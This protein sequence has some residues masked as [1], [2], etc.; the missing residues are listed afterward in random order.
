MPDRRNLLQHASLPGPARRCSRCQSTTACSPGFGRGD[1]ERRSSCAGRDG[2][3]LGIEGS[4][5]RDERVTTAAYRRCWWRNGQKHCRLVDGPAAYGRG[6]Y[7]PGDYYVQDASKLPFGSQRWWTVKER[8]GS[9]GRPRPQR[10][11]A[12]S[13]DARHCALAIGGRAELRVLGA[14]A[15]ELTVITA[16]RGFAQRKPDNTGEFSEMITVRHGC[17][18]SFSAAA[19]SAI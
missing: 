6:G 5:R 15:V 13:G 1:D 2:I 9:A 16:D 19:N 3:E 11:S 8:E 7:C 4:G 14:S 10:Q 12:V 17:V 18:S